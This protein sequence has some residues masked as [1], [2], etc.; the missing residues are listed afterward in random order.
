ME[1]FVYLGGKLSEES[2]A[3]LAEHSRKHR[4]RI[5]KLAE[6]ARNSVIERSP[7]GFIKV[8]IPN[9]G[10]VTWAKDVEDAKVAIAEAVMCVAAYNPKNFDK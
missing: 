10:V 3:R 8:T 4:E 7:D 9:L 2:K 5:N 6:D 1:S